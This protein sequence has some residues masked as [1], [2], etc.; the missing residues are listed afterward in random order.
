MAKDFNI[1][2]TVNKGQGVEAAKEL[3]ELNN[4]EGAG[5]D[6][7]ELEPKQQESEAGKIKQEQS[8][9]V[10]RKVKAAAPNGERKTRRVYSLIRPSTYEALERAAYEQ[11]VSVNEM[12]NIV[13]EMYISQHPN[14]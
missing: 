12:I 5:Q 1:L 2:E 13:L 7:K 8:R 10:Y 6:I 11:G 9:V 3:E 14:A 4:A